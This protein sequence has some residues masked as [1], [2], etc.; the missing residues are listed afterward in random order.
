MRRI[1][2]PVLTT[3]VV[4]LAPGLA[5]ADIGPIVRFSTSLGNIDVRLL[6]QYAP[7]TVQNFLNYVNSGAYNTTFFH[8]SMPGFVLQGGGY[9]VDS[10]GNPQPIPPQAA[11]QNEYNLANTRGTIA[12]AKVANEPN[13]ATDQWFFNLADNS[14]NLDNQNGGFTVFGTVLDQPSLNVM[15]EIAALPVVNDAS[16]NSDFSTLPVRNYIS[17]QTVTSQNYVMTPITVL[18]DTTAPAIT[19]TQPVSGEQFFEGQS[20]T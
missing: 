18:N 10:A 20:V 3:L 6:P 11:V 2:I 5:R 16:Q 1:L 12:M 14:S 8:R 9:Y 4:A 17:G 7:K 15:D 13:S 19:I